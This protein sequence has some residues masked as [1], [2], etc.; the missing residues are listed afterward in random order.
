MVAEPDEEESEEESDKDCDEESDEDCEDGEDDCELAAAAFVAAASALDDGAATRSPL[1]VC[2]WRRSLLGGRGAGVVVR[3][4]AV[5]S[6]PDLLL[7]SRAV[8]ASA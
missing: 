6:G 3:F 7:W 4:V 1:T 2:T 5:P 8:V